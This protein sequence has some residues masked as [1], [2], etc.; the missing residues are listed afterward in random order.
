MKRSALRD[1]L[2]TLVVAAAPGLGCNAQP[3]SNAA[4]TDLAIPP[5]ILF[6]D[7]GCPGDETQHKLVPFDVDAGPARLD[8][9][10]LDCVQ[11]CAQPS[12]VGGITCDL[13]PSSATVDCAIPKYC[14]GRS[15]EGFAADPGAADTV[16]DYLA[17]AAQLEA[18]SVVAFERLAEELTAHRAPRALIEA[19]SSAAIEETRHARDT[20]RLAT[21]HGGSALPLG[22]GVGAVRPLHEVLKENVV[23][24]C[25]R[26]TYGALVALWQ[27]RAAADLAIRESMETIALE[28]I[29]HAELAWAIDR[30]GRRRLGA[31]QRR[32]LDR[33]KRTAVAELVGA[34]A[35]PVAPAL[36]ETVGLPSPERA[37]GF[38]RALDRRFWS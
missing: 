31:R 8:G 33:A 38:L 36:I 30:W 28:E 10:A 14:L 18:A 22:A 29:G 4:M 3:L 35:Q 20:Q 1:Y 11:I 37:R 25:V 17:R 34:S 32:E 15:P 19:A 13:G 26:E 27:A 16:G 12:Y 9:G 24:G 5:T 2:L 21:R 6:S 23:E 7:G